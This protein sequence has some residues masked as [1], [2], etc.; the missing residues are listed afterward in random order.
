MNFDQLR[1]FVAV[2]EHG[3][4]TKAAESLYIS[5]STTSRNVAALE[6]AL[7][8]RLLRRD[9][10]SVGLTPAGDVLFREGTK[11]LKKTEAVETA[12]RDAAT[13]RVGKLTV[14][15]A[16]L[17]C[18][19]FSQIL[20][21]FCR[22]YPEV[23]LGIYRRGIGEVWELVDSGE[24]DVGFGL[25]FVLPEERRHMRV[26]PL[27][28]SRFCLVMA[29]GKEQSPTTLR[30]EE[31]RGQTLL[32]VSAE[33]PLYSEEVAE[34]LRKLGARNRMVR[35][36]TVASLLLQVESGNGMAVLPLPV[37]E[38]C[39]DAY[40]QVELEDLD[41]V[42]ELV[43]FWR[44]DNRNPAVERLAGLLDGLPCL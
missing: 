14:A 41:A 17:C 37:A 40:V 20:G 1:I 8:V 39:G 5:H 33:G 4:F 11:L 2:V 34:Y 29:R 10:R 13:G 30:L 42:F 28:Q 12:V 32:E 31:L 26:H 19:P 16:D 15:G 9:N 6:E 27:V 22:H 18:R 44:A 36:P 7:G 25:S 24:A 3:S 21:D 35:V 23:A 43:V 38:L